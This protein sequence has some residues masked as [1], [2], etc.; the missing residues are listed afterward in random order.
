LL[1]EKNPAVGCAWSEGSSWSK[2]F[3]RVVK[4]YKALTACN[5]TPVFTVLL[6]CFLALLH[7]R[8]PKKPNYIKRL[9]IFCP[10]RAFHAAS[11]CPG[12]GNKFFVV[13]PRRQY[14][15]WYL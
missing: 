5:G 13:K 11:F 12:E 8:S 1:I 15:A 7:L 3:D 6:P 2:T 4:G 14:L 10:D 9:F